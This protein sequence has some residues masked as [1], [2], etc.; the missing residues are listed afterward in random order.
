MMTRLAWCVAAVLVCPAAWAAETCRYSG[1]TSYSGRVIVETT[2]TAGNGETTVDATARVAAKSFGLVD[3]QYLYEEIASWRDG[4]IEQIGVNNRY[5][6]L[7]SIRRQQWDV[8]TRTPTGLIAYRAEANR[9]ADFQ[10]RH[11]AFV[12]HWEPASFGQPWLPDFAAAAAERRAD[13]DLPSTAMPPGLGTPLAL[14]FYWVRW[15]GQR[16]HAVP[17]FLAGFK[18]DTRVDVQVVSLGTESNGAQHLRSS[19][20]HPQLSESEISTGDAWISPDHHLV[21][22][23]FDARGDHASAQGELRLDGCEGEAATR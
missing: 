12:Q 3:W 15:A 22:L 6:V 21:R 9:L 4:E 16:Q 5:S 2:A 7:G 19:V 17:V 14:G 10:A 11:P 18:H 8:F 1:T 23:A 13:L 20:R